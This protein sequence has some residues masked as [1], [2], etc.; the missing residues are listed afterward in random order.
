[1][2]RMPRWRA[3]KTRHKTHVLVIQRC[4][5]CGCFVLLGGSAR[6]LGV[7]E[8]LEA[9]EA[10]QWAAWNDYAGKHQEHAITAVA[11]E[12]DPDWGKAYASGPLAHVQKKS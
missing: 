7:F 8:R 6:Q 5:D 3:P 10:A 1:M 9:A 12:H 2:P 4:E 11:H